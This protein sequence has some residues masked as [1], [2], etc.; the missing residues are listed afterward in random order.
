MK[1]G[2]ALSNHSLEVIGKFIRWRRRIRGW[3]RETDGHG[4]TDIDDDDDDD[5]STN[6]NTI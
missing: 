1:T 5:P 2:Y 3:K 4:G 6:P